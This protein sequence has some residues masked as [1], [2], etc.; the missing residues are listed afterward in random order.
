MASAPA[1]AVFMHGY[2]SPSGNNMGGR[3][4]TGTFAVITASKG[5]TNLRPLLTLAAT[6][7]LGL[8]LAF[9]Q[10]AHEPASPAVLVDVPAGHW[11]A[12]A[13]DLMVKQGLVLGFPDGTYRGDEALNRY[14]I[15][16]LLQRLQEF[17]ALHHEATEAR[18]A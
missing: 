1:L 18:L 13:V 6:A 14:Q 16:V 11:A 12:E 17:T 10:D 3:K 2:R 8:G 7:L 5:V 9:A 4:R 15:A